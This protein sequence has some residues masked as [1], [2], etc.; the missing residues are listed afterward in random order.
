MQRVSDRLG[1][2]RWPLAEQVESFVDFLRQ[3]LR[4]FFRGL[5]DVLRNLLDFFESF[6]LGEWWFVSNLGFFQTYDLV[7]PVIMFIAFILIALGAG[8]WRLGLFALIG[9]GLMVNLGVWEAGMRTLSVVVGAG[10]VC[11]IIGIPVGILMSRNDWVEMTVRPILDFM[12]TLPPFVYLIPA[13]AFFSI[14]SVP[15]LVATVIFG[16]PPIVRLTNH[17][18]RTVDE[19][20][21]EASEAFGSNEWQTLL[22]VQLPLARP[23]ILLGLNQTLM[24]SLSMAVI[25][26][27]IG[28]GGLGEVVLSALERVRVGAGFVGGL[29]IVILAIYLD[30]V[31]QGFGRRKEVGEVGLFKGMGGSLKR[32]F[33]YFLGGRA[34]HEQ[35]R[36]DTG[37]YGG[38][39]DKKKDNSEGART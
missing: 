12:Q 27:M 32:S 23:S 11:S 34:A 24:L 10:V 5:T 4:E 1:I 7:L 38:P 18:I 9:L 6:L 21:V 33:N 35:V 8:G 14:G 28:A 36:E 22:K 31:T 20:V 17:G 3:N 19:E 29:G 37:F 15:A 16:M 2:P 26:A 13:V 30:R 25:A 39:E